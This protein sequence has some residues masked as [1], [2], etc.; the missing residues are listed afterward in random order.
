MG[1]FPFIFIIRE[2]RLS[3]KKK[4]TKKRMLVRGPYQP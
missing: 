4:K 1:Y 3:S 2:P